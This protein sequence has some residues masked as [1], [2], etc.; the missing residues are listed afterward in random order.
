MI[1]IKRALSLAVSQLET[2]IDTARIDAEILLAHT[3]AKTR[4][5]LYAHPEA[6]LTKQQLLIFQQHVARRSLGTPVAHITGT[7]EFWSLPLK[8]NNETLIPR[9]ETEL[10]VELMLSRLGHQANARILD[11]GTGS[12][13]IALALAKERNDWQI[14]ACDCS[15]GALKTAEENALMLGLHNIHFYHSDW[16]EQIKTPAT[17][18]AIV[19][20]PPYIAANDPHLNTGDLRFEP[21]MALVS[22][23]EGLT[24]LE[25]IIKHSLARLEPDGLLLIEHGYDQ[26]RAVTSMLDDYGYKLVQCWK[27]FQGHDRVS[28]G[29][30]RK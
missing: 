22:G 25:H 11:L 2:Y 4:T 10:L 21:I 26:K 12:G 30:K 5:Y 24:A 8:V 20:N 28:G 1:D 27:D 9:P 16:F 7:R 23:R 14:S 19:S 6:L 13:A 17:F 3:L 15:E 18:H 29:I